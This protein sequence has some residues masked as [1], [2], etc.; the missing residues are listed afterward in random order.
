MMQPVIIGARRMKVERPDK[1]CDECGRQF[2][3]SEIYL[4]DVETLFGNKRLFHLECAWQ[5]NKAYVNAEF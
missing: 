3:P 5:L 4:V 2:K 1:R